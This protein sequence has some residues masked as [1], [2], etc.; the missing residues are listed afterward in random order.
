MIAMAVGAAV[1]KPG[2]SA[3]RPLHWDV[4]RV[5]GPFAGRDNALALRRSP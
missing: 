5:A 1:S 3:G 4:V 2:G